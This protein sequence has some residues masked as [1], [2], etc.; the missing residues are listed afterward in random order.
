MPVEA[1]LILGSDSDDSLV[2]FQNPI[3]LGRSGGTVEADAGATLIDARLSGTLSGD[4]GLTKTGYGTLELTA[5]NTYMG[6]T[7]IE[8]GTLVAVL[9]AS[10]PD[11]TSLTVAAG[12][13]FDFDPSLAA[14]PVEGSSPTTLRASAVPEPHA[15]VLLATGFLVLA[16]WR[17]K[18][19]K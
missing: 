7:T 19:G 15:V 11:G 3:N 1:P 12:A 6:G 9:P 16:S 10:L 13:T 4:G 18:N 2:D 8:T 5:G 17:R 14:P